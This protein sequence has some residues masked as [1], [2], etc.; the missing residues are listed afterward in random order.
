VVGIRRLILD[1]GVPAELAAELRARGREAV[2]LAE[3]GLEHA[4]DA[5]VLAADGVLIT[6]VPL[7]GAVLVRGNPYEFVHRQAHALARGS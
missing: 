4:T 1:G 3:I 2:T 5:E 6:T 7:P